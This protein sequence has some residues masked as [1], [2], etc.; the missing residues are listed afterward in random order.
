MLPWRSSWQLCVPGA[1][2]FQF[3]STSLSVLGS[4]TA[5]FATPRA[6]SAIQT[7]PS[8]LT[9]GVCGTASGVGTA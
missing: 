1:F 8:L 5:I 3:T 7:R 9:Q 2:S 4:M 6:L